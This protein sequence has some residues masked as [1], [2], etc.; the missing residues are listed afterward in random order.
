MA[1][2][3]NGRAIGCSETA[4]LRAELERLQPGAGQSGEPDSGDSARLRPLS[5]LLTI[6]AS[7]GARMGTSRSLLICRPIP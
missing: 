6:G 7:S 3:V 5:A 2:R 4:L 1:A